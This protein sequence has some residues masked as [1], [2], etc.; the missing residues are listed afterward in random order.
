MFFP[1]E[2]L[3]LRSSGC[4]VHK[5][6]SECGNQN[7]KTVIVYFTGIVTMLTYSKISDSLIK[8]RFE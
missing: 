7:K 1:L 4:I 6:R 2:L 8:H 3:L 5:P